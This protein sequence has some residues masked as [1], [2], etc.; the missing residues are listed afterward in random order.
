MYVHTMELACC[1]CLRKYRGTECDAAR[2]SRDRDGQPPRP[3]IAPRDGA[4][5]RTPVIVPPTSPIHR[6]RRL[7]CAS[8]IP[9]SPPLS[10][11]IRTIPRDSPIRPAGAV[12]GGLASSR[13]GSLHVKP[14]PAVAGA[15]LAVEPRL[16]RGSIPH[17]PR[18]RR[19]LSIG[20]PLT[21][22]L[23]WA[24]R[25]R[26][27]QRP[28]PVVRAGV[29]WP[30]AHGS[31]ARGPAGHRQRDARASAQQRRSPEAG[32]CASKPLQGE[33]SCLGRISRVLSQPT[34]GHASA[35]HARRSARRTLRPALIGYFART[36]EIG[37][38]PELHTTTSSYPRRIKPPGARLTRA[39]SRWR[40]LA[41]AGEPSCANG[42]CYRPGFVCWRPGCNMPRDVP[43]HPR[44]Q[45][46]RRPVQRPV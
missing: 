30:M 26:P 29:P 44:S 23:R 35:G 31:R 4:L 11:G 6:C 34:R 32:S 14:R 1:T 3:S 2:G 24:G 43:A 33:V 42:H 5:R 16:P 27:W 10:S 39:G 28:G 17:R 15:C 7:A 8:V 18:S 19:L 25:R 41:C 38:P 45:Q 22:A 36:H 21:A 40:R 12:P 20:R 37:P 46:A 13:R 9:P